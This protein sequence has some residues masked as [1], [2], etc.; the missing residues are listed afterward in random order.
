M[1][2]LSDGSLVSSS[3][4]IKIKIWNPETGKL[5][6]TFDSTFIQTQLVRLSD[7]LLLSSG[8]TENKIMTWNITEGKLLKTTE[9][10]NFDFEIAQFVL[11]KDGN[12]AVSLYSLTDIIILNHKTG[13]EVRRIPSLNSDAKLALLIDGSLAIGKCDIAIWD[14][15]RGELVKDIENSEVNSEVQVI[16]YMQLLSD[17]SLACAYSNQKIRI[18]S[19]KSGKLL[20]FF[21]FPSFESGNNYDNFGEFYGDGPIYMT[22]F[23][24][25]VLVSTQVLRAYGTTISKN[26]IVFWE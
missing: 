13:E 19:P 23:N 6:K 9:I 15:S 18:W 5:L 25:V 17:G 16:E 10:S 11:L 21:G 1:I 22:T 26:L 8:S 20:K 24:N 2:E 3:T 7:E 4:D 12:L 14:V